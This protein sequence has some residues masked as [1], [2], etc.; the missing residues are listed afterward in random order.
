MA[1]NADRQ[2]PERHGRGHADI[3]AG[4]D[5]STPKAQR[6]A[7]HLAEDADPDSEILSFMIGG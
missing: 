7:S 1:V 3:E 6:P 2:A 5:S 4:S